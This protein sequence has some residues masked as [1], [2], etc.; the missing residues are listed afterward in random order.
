[1]RFAPRH[2]HPSSWSDLLYREGGSLSMTMDLYRDV[3]V[4]LERLLEPAEGEKADSGADES[5]QDLFVTA[6]VE[7]FRECA[8]W[9]QCDVT[10]NRFSFK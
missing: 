4:V 3:T 6:K 8:F 1:M 5:L 7:Y 10:G 9:G 2:S